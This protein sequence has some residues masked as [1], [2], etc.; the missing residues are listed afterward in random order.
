MNSYFLEAFYNKINFTTK[1]GKST[2]KD[3]TKLYKRMFDNGS[4]PVSPSDFIQMLSSG[5]QDAH[6][7]FFKK[8]FPLV[9]RETNPENKTK[10]IEGS[11]SSQSWKWYIQNNTSIFDCLFGG[12]YEGSV[13]CNTCNN[14]SLTYD[15]FLGIS[16]PADHS[17]LISC[18][19]AEFA[20]EQFSKKVGYKCEKCKNVTAATKR[21]KMDKL[22]KYLILHLKRL[23][24][25]SKKISSFI[26]YNLQL[27]VTEY[28]LLN[29]ST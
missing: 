27:D 15:P 18:L 12:Q 25:G 5:Q 20:D 11:N 23:V 10:R 26:K 4:S 21:T 16:L 13:Q 14:V 24:Q 9:Q 1:F 2:C 7:F 22:P 6:E 28:Y 8:L 3:I 29:L 19:E 17:S